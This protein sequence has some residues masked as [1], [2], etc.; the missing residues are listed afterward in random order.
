MVELE[1]PIPAQGLLG[2]LDQPG[3]AAGCEAERECVPGRAHAPRT[4]PDSPRLNTCCHPGAAS[5]MTQD[6]SHCTFEQ[7]P[8]PEQ[9]RVG[10]GRWLLFCRSSKAT[11]AFLCA[12]HPPPGRRW[13]MLA[14]LGFFLLAPVLGSPPALLRTRALEHP[15]AVDR[16]VTRPGA[17]GLVHVAFAMAVFHGGGDGPIGIRPLLDNGWLRCSCHQRGG[18][19]CCQAFERACS[20]AGTSDAAGAI[21][22]SPRSPR[23]SRP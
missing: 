8:I 13:A 7:W 22:A 12:R 20:R 23:L 1:S 15:F 9:T 16:P 19:K 3:E 14:P 2:L 18:K 6:D 17:T 5:V 4:G 21:A 10:W 11:I